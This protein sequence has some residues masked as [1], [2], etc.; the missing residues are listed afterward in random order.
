MPTGNAKPSDRQYDPQKMPI[1][2]NMKAD[3][4][5]WEKLA[6]FYLDRQSKNSSWTLIRDDAARTA[7]M[8]AGW[9]AEMIQADQ[10]LCWEL[11]WQTFFQY[12]KT[13]LIEH[14]KYEKNPA[15]PQWATQA[16]KSLYAEYAGNEA[17]EV[18]QLTTK[19]NMAKYFTGEFDDW[20]DN[21]INIQ[22]KLKALK[23]GVNESQL[24]SDVLTH[25]QHYLQT[26]HDSNWANFP[27]NF[28]QN[29][30]REVHRLFHRSQQ[31]PGIS[32]RFHSL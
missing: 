31:F 7:K 17:V 3:L 11:L 25:M 8:N 15:H 13:V 26:S 12:K 30:L 16:W 24:V 4:D 9:S 28:R 22:E 20:I 23:Q 2:T 21:I 32:I 18:L 19:L 1:W 10:S 5:N 14:L 29:H 6:S 27:G